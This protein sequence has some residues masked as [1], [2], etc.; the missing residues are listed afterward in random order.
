MLLYI[1]NCIHRQLLL[2][3]YRNPEPLC[4]YDSRDYHNPEFHASRFLYQMYRFSSERKKYNQHRELQLCIAQRVNCPGRWRRCSILVVQP[5]TGLLFHNSKMRA[6][7]TYLCEIMGPFTDHSDHHC[8]ADR[9]PDQMQNPDKNHS[10][11]H[12]ETLSPFY[13]C[14]DSRIYHLL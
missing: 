7:R 4:I 8:V 5:S 2:T 14:Q 13:D 6:N 11:K 9:D 12:Q 10:N 1:L 3:S